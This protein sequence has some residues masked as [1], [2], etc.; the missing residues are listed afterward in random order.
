MSRALDANIL[1][2][3]TEPK[4]TDVLSQVQM[5]Q[6]LSWYSQNKA[7]SDSVRFA[8]D[9]FKKKFKL[10]VS[11]TVKNYPATF[12]FV[13]R[14]VSNGGKLS[15][16]DQ[17]WFDN[18]VAEVKNKTLANK[19]VKK[20]IDT[21]VTNVVSIQERLAEKIAEIAGEL[22]GSIDDYILSGFNKMPSPFAIMQDR[23]KGMHANRIIEMFKKNRAMFDEAL[24]SDDEQIREGYS[25]FSKSEL[26]KLVAYCD[27]II[28][29]AMKIAGQAANNR[30]VRKKKVKTPDQ[31]VTKLN[32]AKEFKEMN[33]V[34]VEPEKIVGAQS[35][36]VFNTKTR[37]L[38]VYQA[39]DV[40]GLSVKGSSITGFSE[41][42]SVQKTVRKPES[43]VPKVV[44]GGKVFLRNVLSEIK[45]VESKLTGRINGDTILLRVMK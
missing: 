3:G 5:A 34:S 7:S 12:G 16:K 31:L 24:N 36:W 38:G 26:K 27:L 29:D 21:A 28:S 22:E 37:K 40:T 25:N 10:D 17:A 11:D 19:S 43:L 44:E 30:K 32:F 42:K 8:N 45:A 33:L 39:E 18:R 6:A 41:T 23:A 2:T 14:I 13:C 20:V 4:F 15:E 35:L 1:M 9:F